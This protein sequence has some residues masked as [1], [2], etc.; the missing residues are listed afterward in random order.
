MTANALSEN[1]G[2]DQAAKDFEHLFVVLQYLDRGGLG[3][4]LQ[5]LE[6]ALELLKGLEGQLASRLIERPLI[7]LREWLGR[8]GRFGRFGGQGDVHLARAA[9]Q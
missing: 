3:L 5:R 4:G 1:L 2:S 6:L 9:A 8:E 7:E